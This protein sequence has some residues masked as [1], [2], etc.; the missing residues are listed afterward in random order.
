MQI[1]TFLRHNTDE[2][3]TQV[4]VW[5]PSKTGLEEPQEDI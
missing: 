1:K 4:V 2:L 3:L 5:N